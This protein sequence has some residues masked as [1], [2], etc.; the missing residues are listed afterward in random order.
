MDYTG[1]KLVLLAPP[2]PPKKNITTTTIEKE[3]TKNGI[4]SSM[5]LEKGMICAIVL[6]RSLLNE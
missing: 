6:A 2:P 4:R 1:L 5:Y 3:R